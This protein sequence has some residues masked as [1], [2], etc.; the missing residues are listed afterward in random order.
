MRHL[1]VWRL[2]ASP[3]GSPLQIQE[4]IL[5]RTKLL[6]VNIL[7]RTDTF[8]VSGQETYWQSSGKIRTL[9]NVLELLS[10]IT[11]NFLIVF[12]CFAIFHKMFQNPEQKLP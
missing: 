4:K 12:I 7:K 9:P 5:F 10:T 2:F 11:V 1:P 6:F 3:K 8:F